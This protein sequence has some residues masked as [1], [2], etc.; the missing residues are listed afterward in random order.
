M[1]LLPVAATPTN[2]TALKDMPSHRREKAENMRFL[3][4]FGL[5]FR[6]ARI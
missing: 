5:V 3:P 6:S 1:R 2:S 4:G